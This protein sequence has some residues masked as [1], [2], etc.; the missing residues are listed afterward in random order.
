[1]FPFRYTHTPNI[2]PKKNIVKGVLLLFCNKIIDNKGMVF[3]DN[4][5]A[6]IVKQNTTQ[7]WVARKVGMDHGAFRAALS[8]QQEPRVSK[9]I[10][11]AD[12][13]GVTVEY[14][15]SGSDKS[16]SFADK[17]LLALARKHIGIL[18]DLETLD[19]L[20]LETVRVQVKAVA[21]ASGNTRDMVAAETAEYGENAK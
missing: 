14:L 9:A 18:E 3:W 21:R 1:M 10:A 17:S 2:H 5:R 16:S 11:I 20:T 12:A 13:L 7:E 15:F 4:V 6:E 8:K 19:P